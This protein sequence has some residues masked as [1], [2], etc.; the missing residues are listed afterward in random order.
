MRYIKSS[1]DGVRLPIHGGVIENGRTR[2]PLTL[3]TVPTLVLVRVWVQIL[4]DPQTAQLRKATTTTTRTTRTRQMDVGSLTCAQVG[5]RVAA[6]TKW[7]ESPDMMIG[8]HINHRL[9]P[10]GRV[11]ARL[12]Q[13]RQPTFPR[14]G[15]IQL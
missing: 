4:G 7:I 12:S 14:N 8:V 13:G 1:E 15:I 11:A 5:V 2:N 10:T 6:L 3:R 9:H